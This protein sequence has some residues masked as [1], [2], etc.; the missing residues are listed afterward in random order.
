MAVGHVDL[1]TTALGLASPDTQ[2]SSCVASL[3]V[4][5]THAH[6]N[7]RSAWVGS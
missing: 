1:E 6:V 7:R 4:G 3:R 5:A 2:E